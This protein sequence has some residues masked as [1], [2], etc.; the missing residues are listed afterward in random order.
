MILKQFNVT[1]YHKLYT[2]FLHITDF[3]HISH[4]ENFFHL[5]ICHVKKFLH[6]ADFFSTGTARGARDK[7]EVCFGPQVEQI[8]TN[9]LDL[10]HPNI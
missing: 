3:L 10:V 7:Y 8:F 9:T 5:T 1:K 6:M 2:S 4:V